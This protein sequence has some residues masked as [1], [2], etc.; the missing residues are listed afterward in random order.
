MCWA[1]DL[2]IVVVGLVKGIRIIDG[3]GDVDE[4]F[5]LEHVIVPR[6]QGLEKLQLLVV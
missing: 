5:V 1:L 4:V 2:S 6:E 3:I